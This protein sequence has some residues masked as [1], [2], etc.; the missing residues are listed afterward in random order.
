LNGCQNQ[1]ESEAQEMN[2]LDFITKHNFYYII[3]H[4]YTDSSIS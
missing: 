1:T 3:I 4:S 2:H